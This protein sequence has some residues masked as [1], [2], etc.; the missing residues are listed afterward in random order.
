MD[1]YGYIWG[2][3]VA[4][5]GVVLGVAVAAS[6]VCERTIGTYRYRVYRASASRV[7][8]V[9]GRKNHSHLHCQ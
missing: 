1:R 7:K 2:K 8:K 9:K 3:A 6:M 4:A 5:V